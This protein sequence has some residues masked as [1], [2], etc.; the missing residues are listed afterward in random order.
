MVR[1]SEWSKLIAPLGPQGPEKSIGVI[2]I[3]Q[4]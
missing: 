3:V 1:L 2:A 4:R